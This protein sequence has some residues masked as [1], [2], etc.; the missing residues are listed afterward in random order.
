MELVN[1]TISCIIDGSGSLATWDFDSMMCGR[2]VLS[3][4][5]VAGIAAREVGKLVICLV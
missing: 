4:L 3:S 1:Y 2:D 5:V